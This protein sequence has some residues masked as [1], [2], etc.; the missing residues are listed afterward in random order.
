MDSSEISPQ[1]HTIALVEIPITHG[2]DGKPPEAHVAWA[3][4]AFDPVAQHSNHAGHAWLRNAASLAVAQSQ[5]VVAQA[6]IHKRKLFWS[7]EGNP[8]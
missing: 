4:G 2:P 8:F 5:R 6:K 3:P 1:L 7:Y